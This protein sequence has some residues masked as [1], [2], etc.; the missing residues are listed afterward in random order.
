MFE[1][2]VLLSLFFVIGH[3]ILGFFG[4]SNSNVTVKIL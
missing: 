4:N 1:G 3:S 2:K